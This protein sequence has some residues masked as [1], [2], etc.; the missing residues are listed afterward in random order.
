MKQLASLLLLLSG[1]TLVACQNPEEGV[2]E[3]E[4]ASEV[5]LALTGMT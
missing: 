2:Y 5:T 4:D 1:T 3:V